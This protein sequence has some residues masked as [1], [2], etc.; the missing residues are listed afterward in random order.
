M[1]GFLN[2]W[3]SLVGPVSWQ[4]FLGS[5]SS[6]WYLVDRRYFRVY[7]YWM[8]E[9]D[10]EFYIFWHRCKMKNLMICLTHF[11]F[12]HQRKFARKCMLGTRG[13]VHNAGEIASRAEKLRWI[14]T[15]LARKCTTLGE[16]MPRALARKNTTTLTSLSCFLLSIVLSQWCWGL[17]S[18]WTT[19]Q[20]LPVWNNVDCKCE[21]K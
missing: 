9:L 7:I 19:S 1:S 6:P 8:A 10:R 14:A 16:R 15:L 5:C 20:S 3:I 4:G 18:R 17:Q 2:P 12:P 21:V 11:Q 13:K